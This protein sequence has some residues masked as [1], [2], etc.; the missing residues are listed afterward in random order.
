MELNETSE[1]VF[2]TIK[3]RAKPTGFVLCNF[4]LILQTNNDNNTTY[5]VLIV[6]WYQELRV[7]LKLELK[8]RYLCIVDVM[9]S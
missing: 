9:F 1:N 6:S 5:N 4:Y 2:K 7:P 8:I 3:T